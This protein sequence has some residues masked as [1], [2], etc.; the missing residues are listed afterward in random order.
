MRITG[1]FLACTAMGLWCAPALAGA[2][3]PG[4]NLRWDQ[5]IADGGVQFRDFACNTNVGS[6]RVVGS[7]E[8]ASDIPIVTGFELYL[9]L[10][11]ASSALPAWWDL[12]NAGA[13]R[14]SALTAQFG[15][16]AGAVNC[17]D[18]GS[19]AAAGGIATYQ[20]NSQGLNH[21][22][23]SL[24][25]GV[26]TGVPVFAGQEYFAFSLTINHTKTVGAG[27][28]AGCLEPVVIFFS[29]ADVQM[30]P[31]GS[32]PQHMLITQG[33]DGDATR[34]VSWQQGY[35][36][37]VQQ[38]CEATGGGLFCFNPT[39]YFDVVTSPP[40]ATRGSTWGAVKSLYR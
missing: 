13:C 1:W 2:A 33:T 39:T 16:P 3:P 15:L 36:V 22:R 40:T 14:S 26:P 28:C 32:V 31:V 21:A 38:G 17:P 19:G 20:L 35:P 5:C 27:A 24:V 18:W 9:H 25:S 30:P 23:I 4:L 10:G 11:S 8:L 7:F 37:N 6:D 12:K 34:W 29:A